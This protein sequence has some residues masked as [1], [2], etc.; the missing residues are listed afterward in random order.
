MTREI[1][2]LLFNNGK[3]LLGTAAKVKVNDIYDLKIAI[4]EE[5][6]RYVANVQALDLVVWRCKEP[7]LSTQDED[8]LQEN[9]LK[10]DFRN[11]GQVVKLASGVK[12]ASL[13]LGEDEVLLVQVPGVISN[14]PSSR[15]GLHSLDLSSK[16]QHLKEK[17]LLNEFHQG[18]NSSVLTA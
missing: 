11:R 18:E 5:A 3:E 9:L 8:E 12:V 4:K 6:S 13:G 15:S 17:N 1:W 10:F 14:F 7:L 16:K 2:Y